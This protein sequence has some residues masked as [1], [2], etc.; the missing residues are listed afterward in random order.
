MNAKHVSCVSE[1]KCNVHGLTTPRSNEDC[2]S[3]SRQMG[4]NDLP[5]VVRRK[6]PRSGQK[7]NSRSLD[8]EFADTLKF[9]LETKMLVSIS[10]SVAR[11]NV[12]AR[13]PIYKISYD[14]L[15]TI[16]R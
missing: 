6:Q 2:R 5:R 10:A 8:C 12:S 15:M 3:A 9:G 1:D 13:G 16:L 14:N 4:V 7:S 11:P